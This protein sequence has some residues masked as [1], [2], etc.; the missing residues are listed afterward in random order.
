MRCVYVDDPVTVRRHVPLILGVLYARRWPGTVMDDRAA[1][2]V[3]MVERSS[4]NEVDGLVDHP[5]LA[6]RD[7][8]LT[9]LRN[10]SAAA[11]ICPRRR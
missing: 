8:W 5:Q 2:G 6:A 11:S 1:G 10:F 7:R 4:L 9:A 3:R